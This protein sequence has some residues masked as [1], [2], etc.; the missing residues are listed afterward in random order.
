MRRTMPLLMIAAACLAEITG[1]LVGYFR[2]RRGD[3]RPLYGVSGAFVPGDPIEHDVVSSAFSGAMG[4]VKKEKSLL[5]FRE[6]KVT[7]SLD[8]PAGRATFGFDRRGLPAWVRFEGG[9]CLVWRNDT[10]EPAPCP[11]ADLPIDPDLPEPVLSAESMSDGWLAV[12]TESA[13]WAVSTG[14]ETRRWRIPEAQP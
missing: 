7:A 3:L 10:P 4:L 1:P 5:V 8:A 14:P 6:G 11:P 12:Q 2:D 13:V 9:A